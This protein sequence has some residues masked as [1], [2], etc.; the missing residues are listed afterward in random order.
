MINKIWGI[1]AHKVSWYVYMRKSLTLWAPHK[2]FLT[3]KWHYLTSMGTTWYNTRKTSSQWS[4]FVF[5]G[6]NIERDGVSDH[7]LCD[8][9]LC[10]LFWRRSKKILKLRI[11]GLCEGNSPVTG[12]FPAQR[13]VTRKVFPFDDVI[14]VLKAVV[15]MSQKSRLMSVRCGWSVIW[16]PFTSTTD[17]TPRAFHRKIWK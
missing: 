3:G 16:K 7:R 10:H 4:L 15:L 11:T 6:R 8:C 5:I 14:M 2:V 12:E 9:F 17:G 13:P 1:Q